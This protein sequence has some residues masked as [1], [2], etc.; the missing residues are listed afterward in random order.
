MLRKSNTD[1]NGGQFDETT[2]NAVWRK[3]NEVPGVDSQ[4]RR[5]DICGAW[6]DYSKHGE[7]IENGTGWEIDHIIPVS[8]GGS[9]NI[10]NLQPLQ[11]ENNRKKGDNQNWDPTRDYAKVAKS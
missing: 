2:K 10:I 1:R 11:W 6:I 4:K 9:D 3:A 7:T 5:K 8:H